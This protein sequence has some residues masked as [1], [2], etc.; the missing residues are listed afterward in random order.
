MFYGEYLY[1]SKDDFKN[2][3]LGIVSGV[4]FQFTNLVVDFEYSHH[5]TDLFMPVEIDSQTY[6]LGFRLQMLILKVGIMF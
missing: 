2:T 1:F 4:G 5:F 6:K 3:L